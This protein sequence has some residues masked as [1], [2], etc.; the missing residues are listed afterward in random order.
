MM[1]SAW[2]LSC[3]KCRNTAGVVIVTQQCIEVT[4]SNLFLGGL[5]DGYFPMSIYVVNKP[6]KSK[7]NKLCGTK[8]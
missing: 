1:Y 8:L 5:F 3:E 6:P 7:T 4:Y 2:F